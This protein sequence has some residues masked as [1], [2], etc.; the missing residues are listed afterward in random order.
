DGIANSAYDWVVES[1]NAYER[2]VFALV[3]ETSAIMDL[4]FLERMGASMEPLNARNEAALRSTMVQ[5]FERP[6]SINILLSYRKNAFTN[7]RIAAFGDEITLYA[8]LLVDVKDPTSVKVADL[9]RLTATR[10]EEARALMNVE[11]H[12]NRFFDPVFYIAN[13]KHPFV[14]SAYFTLLDDIDGEALTKAVEELR[15]RFP[16]FY[17]RVKAIEQELRAIANPLPVCVVAGWESPVIGSKENNYHLLTVRYEGRR[18]CVEV[19]HCLTDGAGIMPYLKALLY[20]YLT[21][22]TG[23]R[24]NPAGLRLPGTDFVE[25]ELGCPFPMDRVS[26]VQKPR[27]VK[28]PVDFYRLEEGPVPMDGHKK[29]FFVQISGEDMLRYCRAHDG[30]PNAVLAVLMAKAIRDV[31]A[32]M[33]RD[34]TI[35]VATDPKAL[36]GNYENYHFASDTIGL[37]FPA[38]RSL[39]D[40]SKSCTIA[41]G[42]I[43]AQTLED[44]VLYGV[45]QRK[46]IFDNLG[47]LKLVEQ[48]IDMLKDLQSNIVASAMVSYTGNRT[49]G[50]MDAY[51]DEFYC[52]TDAAGTEILLENNYLNGTFYLA[53]IQSFSSDAYVRALLAQ[54]EKEGI[55]ATLTS[56]EDS[57]TASTRF[58]DAI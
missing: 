1:E 31:D 55:G 39:D 7:E 9:L 38:S 54:L 49:L 37:D 2:D 12:K 45:K 14:M 57:W 26:K 13:E 16:Y 36:L 34:I 10:D 51:I 56:E 15:E 48:K 32:A 8:D 6:D 21:K 27:L 50:D 3:Y 42:Q 11:T 58:E 24:L 22:A 17:V 52:V 4:S 29:L 33:D 5:V 18:L 19:S 47:L 43:I 23:A 25:G 20:L 30:S 44:N 35:G 41:R 53:I 46:G 28:K 40:M